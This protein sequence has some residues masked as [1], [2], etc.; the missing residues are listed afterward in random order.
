MDVQQVRQDIA[1][2]V[3]MCD[4]S[5]RIYSYMPDMIDAPAA[6]IYPSPGTIFDTYDGGRN[7]QF[8]LTLFVGTANIEAAQ[9]QLDGWISTGTTS[10]IIDLLKTQTPSSVSSLMPVELRNYGIVSLT[11]GGTRYLW[12]EIIVDVLA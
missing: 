4:D 7:P 3:E 9:A 10:S 5:I 11:D 1:D 8:V 6:A 12:A 2:I